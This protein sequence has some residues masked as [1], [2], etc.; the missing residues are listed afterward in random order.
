M[1]R[2]GPLVDR[3]TG[4]QAFERPTLAKVGV[5]ASIPI[6]AAVGATVAARLDVQYSAQAG[7][8]ML[9]TALLMVVAFVGLAAL[10]SAIWGE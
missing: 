6:A 7:V 5:V 4:F 1:A 2:D 8:T 3:L 9:L 10:D